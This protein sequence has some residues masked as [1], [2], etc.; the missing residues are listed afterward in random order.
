VRARRVLEQTEP[1]LVTLGERVLVPEFTEERDREFAH[2]LA[3]LAGAAHG[4][5]Q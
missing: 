4:L 2:P 3:P 1:S 5:L